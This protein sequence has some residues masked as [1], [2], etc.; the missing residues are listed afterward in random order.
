MSWQLGSRLVYWKLI[1]GHNILDTEPYRKHI[2][3]IPFTNFIAYGWQVA[4]SV[5]HKGIML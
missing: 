4:N 1:C 5:K 2:S 3:G